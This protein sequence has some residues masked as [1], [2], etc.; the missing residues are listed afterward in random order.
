MLK[1][2]IMAGKLKTTA[3]LTVFLTRSLWTR[4]TVAFIIL[5][6]A[7]SAYLLWGFPVLTPDNSRFYEPVA[8][9]VVDLDKT[10]LSRKIIDQMS[11]IELVEAVYV[12]SLPQAQARMDRNES[13][14]ILIIPPSFFEI[15]LRAQQRPPLTVHLNPRKPVEASLFTR[16][17][18]SMKE[19]IE[20]VQASFFAFAQHAAPL[21][22]DPVAFEL[23]VNQAATRSALLV[24]GRR[25]VVDIDETLKIHL[26]SFV[27]SSVLCLLVLQSTLMLVTHIQA[28][29]KSGLQD[30]LTASGLSGWQGLLARQLGGLFWLAVTLIPLLLGLFSVYPDMD[31]LLFLATVLALYWVCALAA[32]AVAQ[33]ARP[34]RLLLLGIWF[35]ILAMF[36]ASGCLYPEQLLPDVVV[37]VGKKT[38]VYWAFRSCYRAL[39]GNGPEPGS[40]T[41]A[42]VFLALTQTAALLAVRQKRPKA[43]G[44]AT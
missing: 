33:L 6:V 7:L 23:L 11:S 9:S 28:D 15:S 37:A 18:D 2:G 4:Q 35:G 20:G 29:R 8:F 31:R 38:P 14:F 3:Q 13:V 22:T 42:L 16:L 1:R 44:G 36:L 25:S 5:M 34:D 26:V 21:Y 39:Q 10:L 24:F 30:R 40:V 32:Q 41:A 19:S 27:V 12:E 43:R 17:L